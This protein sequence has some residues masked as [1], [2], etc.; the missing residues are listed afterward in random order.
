MK[1]LN[2]FFN[3][4]RSQKWAL[5]VPERIYKAHCDG[6]LHGWG[7]AR[8]SSKNMD[9]LLG[10]LKQQGVGIKIPFLGHTNWYIEWIEKTYP[11]L[12]VPYEEGNPPPFPEPVI[13]SDLFWDAFLERFGLTGLSVTNKIL[14][15]EGWG[16]QVRFFMLWVT[17]KKG[18]PKHLY[19]LPSAERREVSDANRV[20]RKEYELTSDYYNNRRATLVVLK[21]TYPPEQVRHVRRQLEEKLRKDPAEII[22]YGLE[23]GLLK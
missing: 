3:T 6:L 15:A 22:R 20:L 17:V 9:K 4:L 2:S 13:S 12:V 18:G 21:K 19:G 7:V 5:Y 16:Y 23:R 8:E 14:T 10:V 11:D 1:D